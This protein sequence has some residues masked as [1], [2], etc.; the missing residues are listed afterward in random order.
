MVLL[1][2][3]ENFHRR[4]GKNFILVGKKEDRDGKKSS[5]LKF[6]VSFHGRPTWAKVQGLSAIFLSYISPHK[7]AYK[8]F[9]FCTDLGLEAQIHHGVH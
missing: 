6:V 8:S 3:T 9:L 2:P 5:V 4:S 7:K 1:L